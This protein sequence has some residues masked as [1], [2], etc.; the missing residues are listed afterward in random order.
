MSGLL[1][2][3]PD[4]FLSVFNEMIKDPEDPQP[5]ICS[6][7]YSLYFTFSLINNCYLEQVVVT[8]MQI[9]SAM[10]N[11]IS[12][13][14]NS[15]RTQVMLVIFHHIVVFSPPTIFAIFNNAWPN[16]EKWFWPFIWTLSYL[17]HKYAKYSI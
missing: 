7:I 6:A 4:D 3:S 13:P 10:I 14:I 5:K 15:M 12:A 2:M 1:V 11:K 8:S 17:N 9:L 16:Y